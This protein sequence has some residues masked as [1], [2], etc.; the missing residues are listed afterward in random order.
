MK[1]TPLFALSSLLFPALSANA[2]MNLG[3][4]EITLTANSTLTYDS[5]ISARSLDQGDTVL[6]LRTGLAY[7]RP[8]RNFVLGASFGVV[9]QRYLDFTENDD[10][11]FYFDVSITPTERIETS[12][13]TITGSLIL[14]SRT[15]TDEQVGDIVTTRTYG[16]RVGVLYD[17]NR[18]YNINLNASATRDDPES[19]RYFQQDRYTAGVT[20]EVPIN[21][22]YFSEFGV[23]Y[24]RNESDR[25][26]NSQGDT[27]TGFV[28]L[29]GRILP[30]LSGTIRVGAQERET[31]ALGSDTGPYASGGLTWSVGELTSLNFNLSHQFGTTIDDRSTES[32]SA[33]LSANRQLNRRLTGFA[34][35]RYDEEDLTSAGDG[36]RTDEE[37]SVFGGLNFDLNAWSNLSMNISYSDQTSSDSQFEFDRWRISLSASARW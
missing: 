32:T 24:S 6:N 36:D 9:V 20:L 35:L 1:P 33:S 25:T 7:S 12:R 29:S 31:R 19:D 27:Y 16:A 37:Y 18:H 21:Q 13:F 8:S 15:S 28:G 26:T 23:S 3:E 30:K 4:G 22:D 5:R 2:F 14:D 34:G 10:E 11:N 17:P